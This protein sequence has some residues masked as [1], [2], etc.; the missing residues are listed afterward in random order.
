MLPRN[1]KAAPIASRGGFFV[2]AHRLP[3]LLDF[4][5]VT[6]LNREKIGPVS[7]SDFYRIGTFYPRQAISVHGQDA[8]AAAFPD[9]CI[10][11]KSQQRLQVVPGKAIFI[12]GDQI[13]GAAHAQGAHGSIYFRSGEAKCWR[14]P[15][16]ALR[17]AA[18]PQHGTSY[19]GNTAGIFVG[20][21]LAA[22]IA[23]PTRP[24]RFRKI[25]TVEA[26][27]RTHRTQWA[28]FPGSE[29][30][31][32]PACAQ[33]KRTFGYRPGSVHARPYPDAV[34][35][36]MGSKCAGYNTRYNEQQSGP[37]NLEINIFHD[38]GI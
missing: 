31:G 37:R 16:Q 7:R 22:K 19:V 28:N 27:A 23:G 18:P 20:S 38:A 26:D 29:D 35:L 1:G 2:W 5:C 34:K 12:K 25:Q 33:Q 36:G 14:K 13:A 4:V 15:V 21:S 32:V 9:R 24:E 10:P 8:D 30:C 6:H 17:N 11:L 3:V